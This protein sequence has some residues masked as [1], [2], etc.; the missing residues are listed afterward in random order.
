[1][2]LKV[3]QTCSY[4]ARMQCTLCL[5]THVS[6]VLR[7]H[8]LMLS[9]CSDALDLSRTNHGGDDAYALSARIGPSRDRRQPCCPRTRETWQVLH[10][11]TSIRA[12]R[13][14]TTRT[15]RDATL[16][17][18]LCPSLLARHGARVPSPPPA[19]PP[20]RGHR[21]QHGVRA[22]P[23]RR[24][25]SIGK[26]RRADRGP[27]GRRGGPRAAGALRGARGRSRPRHATHARAKAGFFFSPS[28]VRWW[29]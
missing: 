8:V 5:G 1:M 25:A 23:A 3:I 13:A 16:L 9:T 26:R 27:G 21:W 17:P 7:M 19:R 18:R 14:R 2:G 24:A 10:L 6:V 11:A 29:P 28:S 20:D 4:V 22:W 12:R 15:R